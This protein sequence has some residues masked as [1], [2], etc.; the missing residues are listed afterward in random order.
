M[1]DSLPD[2]RIRDE[3]LARIENDPCGISLHHRD[4]GPGCAAGMAI[5]IAFFCGVAAGACWF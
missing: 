3:V 1:L 5:L 4:C 2:S